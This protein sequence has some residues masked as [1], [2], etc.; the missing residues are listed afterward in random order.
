MAFTLKI[1]QGLETNQAKDFLT[2]K[3]YDN[4]CDVYYGY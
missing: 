1:V 2:R 3:L 4:L